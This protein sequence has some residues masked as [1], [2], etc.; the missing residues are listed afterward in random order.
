MKNKGMAWLGAATVLAV[1]YATFDYQ[2]E[3]HKDERKAESSKI[4]SFA[5]DQIKEIDILVKEIAQTNKEGTPLLSNKIKL[6]RSTEGWKIE[7][8]IQETAD[9]GAVQ[10]FLDGLT[11]EK[12]D[13]VKTEND[14][15]DWKV[16]GLDDPRGQIDVVNNLGEKQVLQ[17][18][19]KKNYQGEAF[20]RRD[21]EKQVLLGSST[22]FAKLDKQPTD[23]RDKRIY[24]KPLATVSE[25][26]H[27]DEVSK[28]SLKL[29]DGQ[30]VSIE[31]PNWKLDQNKIRDFLAAFSN[32]LVTDFIKESP[33]SAEEL[34]KWGF[35]KPRATF[36]LK[37][38]EAPAWSASVARDTDKNNYVRLDDP[39]F[40]V[41]V[42]AADAE[43]LVNVHLD[44]LRDRREPFEF[45]RQDVK[46]FRVQSNSAET[47]LEM[48][49]TAWE[50][51]KKADPALKI[52]SDKMI[53]F[54]TKLGGLEVG[55]FAEKKLDLGSPTQTVTLMNERGEMIFDLKLGQ[56]QKRRVNNQ[57]HAFVMTLT[58]LYPEPVWVEE[59]LLK[60]V[61]ISE[62]LELPKPT[63]KAPQ[64]PPGHPK[65]ERPE[66]QKR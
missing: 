66:E 25:I 53:G 4:V 54:L 55:E 39:A 34:K 18:S 10:D 49:S 35:Q 27:S 52:D 43:K 36:S 5:P 21:Q 6:T 63:E 47:D 16:F 50:A 8:P 12:A 29:K 61:G 3:K 58:N 7:D 9:Q 64:L 23:F 45:K 37:A 46:K 51:T 31:K 24:R 20:L 62:L 40:V 14:Q 33:P 26:T 48:K 57:D 13:A 17:I 65:V 30:W 42:T 22:W 60:G 19:S 38:G 59:A 1:A 44:T 11:T 41:K 28:F 32:P 2:F 15:V 56:V